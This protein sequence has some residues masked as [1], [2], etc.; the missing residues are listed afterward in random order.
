MHDPWLDRLSEYLDEE[1]DRSD[2]Q[3]LAAHLLGC[4]ECVALLA[5]LK[6]VRARARELKDAPVPA[7]LWSRIEAAIAEARRFSSP[8]EAATP[9]RASGGRRGARFSFSLPELVAACVGI[10]ILSGGSVFAVLK[11]QESRSPA[12]QMSVTRAPESPTARDSAPGPAPLAEGETTPPE[13]SA[14]PAARTGAEAVTAPLTPGSPHEE[15]I[16]ELRKALAKERHRLDPATI[17]ALEANLTII[18]LAIDQAKRAL[19][20]DPANTYVKEHLA[21]TMRRKVELLQRATILASASGP[22]GSR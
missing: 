17:R 19:A 20:A 7:A 15:A 4:P 10:A 3:T 16:S 11:R 2:R 22:E 1:L 9:R 6:R 14:V 21:E 5:D 12:P 18:D 13:G 8:A